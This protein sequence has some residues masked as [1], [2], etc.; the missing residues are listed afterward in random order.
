MLFREKGPALGPE[1]L[2]MWPGPWCMLEKNHAVFDIQ[3]LMK[4]YWPLMIPF[5]TL[6]DLECEWQKLD[7]HSDYIKVSL[8]SYRSAGTKANSTSRISDWLAITGIRGICPQR[9]WRIPQE[10]YVSVH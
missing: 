2:S 4:G 3:R 9:G 5:H 1:P 6:P 7:V 8:K 10:I